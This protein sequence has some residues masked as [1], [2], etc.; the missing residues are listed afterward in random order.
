MK[1]NTK[2]SNHH[3]TAVMDAEVSTE[4]RTLQE[5]WNAA[6]EYF[7]AGQYDTDAMYAIYNRMN[8]K[9]GFQD[10]ANVC[11][12]VYADT[13]WNITFMDSSFLSKSLQQ[14]LALSASAADTYANSAIS[15]WRGILCRKNISDVGRIPTSD[16]FTQSI[17]IVCNQNTPI[18]PE[19]LIKNWNSSYWQ[20]PQVGKNYIYVRG[21]NVQFMDPIAT[22][23]AQMFYSTGGFNQPPTSWIQCLTTGGNETSSFI[24]VD[25]KEG[26]MPL[27]TRGV[28]D[29]FSL[30]PTST[31][32]ICVIA[33]V[34]TEFFTKNQPKNI[35][36]GN[37]NSYTYITHNGS[38]AWHNFD[39]QKALTDTLNFYNQDETPETFVFVASCKNVP[40]GSKISLSCEDKTLSFT[41]GL[42]EINQSSQVLRKTVSVPGNFKGA[43]KV[44]L[45]D[46]KGNLL[47]ASASVEFRMA[48][49]IKPGHKS[50]VAAA[51]ALPSNFS[52]FKANAEIE[53]SLGTYTLT[54]GG[55]ES[56]K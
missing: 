47:P 3:D 51:E 11:S 23:E 13:Y 29:S 55:A 18:Q 2:N 52:L 22:P 54:G 6:V 48:W 33:A 38:S 15:Q 37:W 28:S 9:L 10:I 24:L 25:G 26:P 14:A 39:P 50:Y 17:D 4:I 12:G 27:G 36:L 45:E 34:S 41:T 21:A 1:S 44:R 43:L 32:H 49:V 40:V 19:A 42:L 7:N 20:T 16:D 8:P 53:L 46:P 56:R 30:E 31:D 5:M 35:P